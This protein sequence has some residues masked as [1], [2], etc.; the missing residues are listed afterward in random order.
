[1]FSL[2]SFD[3]YKLTHTKAQNKQQ[4]KAQEQIEFQAKNQHQTTSEKEFLKIEYYMFF[5]RKEGVK[6][7]K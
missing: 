1:M 5:L 7:I 4:K 2:L 3:I 6:K